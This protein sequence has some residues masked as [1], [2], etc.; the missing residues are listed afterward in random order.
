MG[1][2]V[3]RAGQPKMLELGFIKQNKND[4]VQ[5]CDLV[6]LD[7]PSEVHQFV[8]R[9]S[10]GVLSWILFGC[11]CH[12]KDIPNDNFEIVCSLSFQITLQPSDLRVILFLARFQKRELNVEMPDG[13][14]G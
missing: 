13:S 10:Q 7:F 12:L 4:S 8:E 14:K 5:K 2:K 1:E 6:I 3:E 9:A 11:K